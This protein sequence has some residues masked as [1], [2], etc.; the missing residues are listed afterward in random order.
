MKEGFASVLGRFLL[1]KGHKVA[2]MDTESLGY[3]TNVVVGGV[4]SD[5]FPDGN[6]VAIHHLGKLGH[7]NASFGEQRGDAKV[8]LS[9]FHI[10]WVVVKWEIWQPRMAAT[11]TRRSGRATAK[12]MLA[13]KD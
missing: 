9:L 11:G 4:A 7:G 10:G 1:T 12:P 13:E 6:V 8:V 2:N 3:L 5:D